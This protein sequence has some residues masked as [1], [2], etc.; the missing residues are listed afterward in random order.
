MINID[1]NMINIDEK[2]YEDLVRKAYA[3]ELLANHVNSEMEKQA[4]ARYMMWDVRINDMCL[5]LLGLNPDYYNTLHERYM[6]ERDED[7]N[8]Q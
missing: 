8:E 6:G 2:K 1:E 5:E 4:N 3:M 7:A